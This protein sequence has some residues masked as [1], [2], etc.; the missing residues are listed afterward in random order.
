MEHTIGSRRKLIVGGKIRASHMRSEMLDLGGITHKQFSTFLG[1]F[2]KQLYK[3]FAEKECLYNLK[4]NFKDVSKR[5]NFKKWDSMSV[6]AVF[7]C[8]DLKSAY[9]QI[10]R[11]LE[12]IDDDFYK[13]YLR[14]DTYKRAKRYCVSFLAR[15]NKMH[16]TIDELHYDVNCEDEVF[17]NVYKNIRNELYNS[18]TKVVPL[19]SDFI[20]YNIDGISVLAN[21]VDIVTDA[22]IKAGLDYKITRC[23]KINDETYTHGC[24]SKNFKIKKS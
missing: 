21:D 24:G 10:A 11:K 13:L 5:K 7:Y 23:V 17:R 6:G 12:Y 22:F 1:S 9:W 2:S 8:V 19:C 3:S 18:I 14:N 4:I 16:Y 15:K 20:E